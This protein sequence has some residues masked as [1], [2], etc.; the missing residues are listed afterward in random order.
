MVL[1]EI[2]PP[3]YRPLIILIANLHEHNLSKT[4]DMVEKRSNMKL[5]DLNSKPHGG[6][7][8]RYIIDQAI[9]SHFY[10]PPGSEY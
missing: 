6:K 7:S 10:P 1:V 9:V 2:I 5:Y 3:Q 4:F 8:L